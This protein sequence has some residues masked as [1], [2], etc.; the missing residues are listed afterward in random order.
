MTSHL[1]ILNPDGQW[2]GVKTVQPGD[3]STFTNYLPGEARELYAFACSPDNSKTNVRKAV[4]P[5]NVLLSRSETF[6]PHGQAWESVAQ[7]SDGEEFRLSILARR[8]QEVD[9]RVVHKSQ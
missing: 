1:E 7:L 8:G 4:N 6:V 5:G 9:I 2:V 3:E